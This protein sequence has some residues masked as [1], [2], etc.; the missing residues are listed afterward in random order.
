MTE[1]PPTQYKKLPTDRREFLAILG[2]CALALLALLLLGTTGVDDQNHV[3]QPATGRDLLDTTIADLEARQSTS[4]VSSEPTSRTGDLTTIN[5]AS[6]RPTIAVNLDSVA[7][8]GS[9]NWYGTGPMVI[10]G[11]EYPNSL[12]VGKCRTGNPRTFVYPLENGWGRFLA[13]VGMREGTHPDAASQ[14]SFA[15]ETGEVLFTSRLDV[16]GGTVAVELPLTELSALT[17]TV[18]GLG[19]VNCQDST[20]GPALGHPRFEG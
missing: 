11:S 6:T 10:G 7:S 19:G 3:D 15:S 18:V 16:S 12:S 2:V 1:V 20:E 17:I 13:V 5:P 14:I 4:A 9:D 8:A